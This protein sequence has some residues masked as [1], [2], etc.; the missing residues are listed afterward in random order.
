M[1]CA[2]PTFKDDIRDVSGN[3]IPIPCGHCFS[4]RLDMQRLAID[5]MH[6]A[7]HSH[8]CSA[9]VTFTY[10]DEHLVYKDGFLQPTLSKDDLRK[11]LD[12]IRHQVDIPFE[13]YCCGEYGEQ[14]NRPHYHALFFGLDYQL[15]QSVFNKWNK[16]MVKVL[17]CT[18]KAFRYVSKYITKPYSKTWNDSHYYDFGLI[19]PF[20]KMSR[21]LGVSVFLDHLDVIKEKGFFDFMSRRIYVNRYYFN[22]LCTYSD[23]LILQRESSISDKLHQDM[24]MAHRLNLPLDVYRSRKIVSREKALISK[25]LRIKSNLY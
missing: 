18:P 11:Y 19:P 7:F 3:L 24:E 12:N 21:G 25:S 10:D 1:S 15:H 16:G 13:Y 6:C 20:R 23:R 8:S 14:L 2:N 4:C 17:P 9:F 5:R 22:K